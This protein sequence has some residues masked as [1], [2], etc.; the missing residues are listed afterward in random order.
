[1]R[2]PLENAESAFNIVNEQNNISMNH[3]PKP[4]GHESMI[5]HQNGFQNQLNQVKARGGQDKK[6]GP[7]GPVS[8]REAIHIIKRKNV[9]CLTPSRNVGNLP[10]NPNQ[11]HPAWNLK[12]KLHG[13]GENLG[14]QQQRDESLFQ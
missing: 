5:V 6:E 1:M 7:G 14:Q 9:P 3:Q 8:P 4:P 13:S 10:Q 12:M 2:N 11:K